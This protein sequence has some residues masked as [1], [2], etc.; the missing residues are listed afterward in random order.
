VNKTWRSSTSEEIPTLD[1]FFLDLSDRVYV[2]CA[3]L[4]ILALIL[5]FIMS[6]TVLGRH[7]YALGGN[8]QAAVLSGIRTENVKWFAYAFSAISAS[9][10]GIFYL[11]KGSSLA[12]TTMAAGHELNAIAAAVVGGASLQGGIGTVQGTLLGALFLQA[13][14][15]S[16]QRIIKTNSNTYEGLIVGIVVVLAVTVNQL[17]Q[18]MISGRQ[19]FAGA[20][21][22]VSIPILS[23]VCGTLALMTFGTRPGALSGI[24]ALIVLVAFKAFELARAR[25]S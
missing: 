7:V 5:W 19:L 20:L 18:I 3:V 11:S 2:S 10:A 14:V 17:R 15:D 12:P 24:I 1:P 25:K 21:G 23:L 6:R 8:E 13:V 16:V 22:I 4:L 9:I